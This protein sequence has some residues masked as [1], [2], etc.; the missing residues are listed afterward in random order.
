M[1]K[2][3]IRFLLFAATLPLLF[4]GKSLELKTKDVRPMMEEMLSYH[5]EHKE[6]SPLLFRRALKIFISQF[7]PQKLYFTTSELRPYLEISDRHLQTALANYRHDE[8]GEFMGLNRLITKAIKRSRE[9][10]S[11][12]QR[13]LTL[14]SQDLPVEPGETHLEY[15]ANEETLKARQKRLLVRFLLD[16]KA[17]HPERPWTPL[18]REKIGNLWNHRLL[19]YEQHYVAES[20]HYLALHILK[21]LARSLDAHSSFYGSEEALEIRAS[22]EKQFEGIGI[23]LREGIDGIEIAGLVE[24]GPAQKNGSV[25]P[26]DVI[27]EING[28][29]HTQSTYE[30]V[31]S[32]LQTPLN[33]FITL[34]LKRIEASGEEKILHVQLK[35]EKIILENERV[36]HSFIPCEQGIIGKITLPS[37]YESS[38]GSSCEKDIREALRQLKK[39]GNLRGLVLDLRENSGGF[40]SQAVKVSSLFITNGVVVISKYAKGQVQYLRNLDGKLYYDGPLI[41]LTSRLSASAAEIVAQALQDYGTAL[42]VGDE[43]TY[44]KGTIQF[45]TLTDSAARAFFKVT[46]GKYYTVSGKSTQI[47]GVHADI[48]IPSSL[49]A[50][51]IGERFLEYP[52]SNDYMPP[53]YQDSLSDLDL[54]AKIWFEKNYLPNLQKKLSKWHALLP[55][56]LVSSAKRLQTNEEALAFLKELETLQFTATPSYIDRHWWKGSDWQMTEALSIVQNMIELYQ[57]ASTP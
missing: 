22:L 31:L 24:G 56:L 23:L 35:R 49:A 33:A 28:K 9:W 47:E 1:T 52:L 40:L 44:G 14:T 53:V 37:F 13:E 20:P 57:K 16:E 29:D 3:C 10:R 32:A 19:R 7:D 2:R 43:R 11:E 21:S 15:A 25:S 51:R 54:E 6:L 55:E 48:V 18:I 45:Q 34:G 46:V 30:E 50:F 36:R 42:V 26:G 8:F 39:Q 41:L 38:D 27:V 12:M 5:V 4:S 17:E